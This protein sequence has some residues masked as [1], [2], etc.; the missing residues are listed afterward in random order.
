MSIAVYPGSFDPLTHGHVDLIKRVSKIFSKVVV[1]V[2]YSSKKQYL[3]SAEERR[4]LIDRSLGH[5]DNVEVQI[6]DGLTTGF[7]KKIGAKII[8][9]GV[10]SAIDFDSEI[11]LAQMNKRLAADIETLVLFP[12]AEFQFISSSAIKEVAQAGGNLDAFVPTIV[13]QALK[14]KFNALRK[15]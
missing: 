1:L 12:N 13:A 14:E 3:F 11:V 2:A 7:L 8:I 5:L 15:N 10:R 4:S 6:H 9:R